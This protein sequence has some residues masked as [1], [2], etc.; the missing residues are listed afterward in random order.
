MPE[1]SDFVFHDFYPKPKIDLKDADISE[2]ARQK[3]QVQQLNYDDIVSKH[4]SDVRF[5]NLEEMTIDTDP[6]LPPGMGKH[7]NYL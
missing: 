3:L 7:T 5:A 6:Q 2:V 1:K 4:R